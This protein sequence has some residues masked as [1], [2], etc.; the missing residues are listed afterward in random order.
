MVLV[1]MLGQRRCLIL[2]LLKLYMLYV[3]DSV[4]QSDNSRKQSL[5][6]IKE[7]V[8][9]RMKEHKDYFK[10]N[11]IIIRKNSSAVL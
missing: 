5:A 2:V 8:N 4:V 1:N 3:Y 10:D 7:L 6:M 9:V 11:P